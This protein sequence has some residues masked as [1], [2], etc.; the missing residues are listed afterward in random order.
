MVGDVHGCVVDGVVTWKVVGRG[1]RQ[2]PTRGIVGILKVVIG[3]Y[4]GHKN[5]T[6]NKAFVV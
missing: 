4:V 5:S 6:G 3:W 2:I 1:F